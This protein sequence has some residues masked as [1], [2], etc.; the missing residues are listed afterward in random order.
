MDDRE[1]PDNS[2]A[3]RAFG[4]ER[5]GTGAEAFGLPGGF[6]PPV[7]PASPPPRRPQTVGETGFAPPV[8]PPPPPGR[9]VSGPGS[10]WP[11]PPGPTQA[12][13]S[14]KAN[15]AL[16]LGIVSWLIC[17]IVLSVMAMVFAQQ[18]KREID[19]SSGTIGGRGRAEAAMWIGATSLVVYG[20]LLVVAL[21]GGIDTTS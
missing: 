20:I 1:R 2:D 10:T 15:T 4:D 18:A 19:A 12:P 8:P 5:P 13:M 9:P 3:E 21:A 7:P 14:S 6:E 17:P 11:P 16:V